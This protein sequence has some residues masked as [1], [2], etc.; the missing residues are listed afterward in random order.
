MG[1]GTIRGGSKQ[2]DTPALQLAALV[3]NMRGD[4]TIFET[5]VA[6]AA[7]IGVLL[8]GGTRCRVLVMAPTTM[9]LHVFDEIGV[10]D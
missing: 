4:P 2:A 8:W 3:T 10:F 6:S 5:C 1:E 7:E 9:A